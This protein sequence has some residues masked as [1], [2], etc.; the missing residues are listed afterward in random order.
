MKTELESEITIGQLFIRCPDE[1][2]DFTIKVRGQR[3]ICLNTEEM[4]DIVEF[5]NGHIQACE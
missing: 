3:S 1:D 4:K 2:G 5:L